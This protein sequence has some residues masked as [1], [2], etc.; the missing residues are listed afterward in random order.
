[1]L[2]LKYM[3]QFAHTENVTWDY[4]PIGIWSAVETQVGV[5]VACMPAMR[6]LQ[7]SLRARFFPKP[8]TSTKFSEEYTKGSSRKKSFG[9]SGSRVWPS[10]VDRSR[11]STF[12]RTKS[13]KEDFMR[14]D[15]YELAAGPGGK[16][17]VVEDRAATQSPSEGSLSRSW[18]ANEDDMPL[19][20]APAMGG[21]PLSAIVVQKEYSV[22]SGR[23]NPAEDGER[24]RY[25]LPHHGDPLS[26]ARSKEDPSWQAR[27]SSPQ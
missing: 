24:F 14:L 22:N 3:V 12:T 2:R 4:L 27:V 18:E 16:T 15:E 20:T 5:I 23:Q 8:E 26:Q 17:G 10:K 9:S 13:D 19:A 11:L 25:S 7:A 6:S 1:M 21:L